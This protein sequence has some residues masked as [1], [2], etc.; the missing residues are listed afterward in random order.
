[1]N[2]QIISNEQNY[3]LFLDDVKN[4]IRKARVQVARKANHELIRLYWALGK[5]I[6]E[7]QEQLGWGKSVVE[8]LALDLQKPLKA[9]VVS[10]YATYGA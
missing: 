4:E 6:T 5:S 8:Q 2:P 1:M 3:Q 7:K 10:P 9:A